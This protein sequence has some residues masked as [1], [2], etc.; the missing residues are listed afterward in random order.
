MPIIDHLPTI[1]LEAAHQASIL[2]L[3]SEAAIYAVKSFGE[4]S[5][6]APVAAAILGAMAGHCFNWWLGR[7]VMKLPSSPKHHRYYETIAHYFNRYGFILLAL[8]FVPLGNMLVLIAGMLGT[9]LKKA[10]PMIALGLCYHY[11][12]LLF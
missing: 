10:L 4:G 9:P 11:G 2:P 5:M 3:A 6:A 1:F 8:A 7:A 12:L